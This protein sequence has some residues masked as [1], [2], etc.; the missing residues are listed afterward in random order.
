MDLCTVLR[1]LVCTILDAASC[2]DLRGHVAAWREAVHL[3]PNAR[4][5][6]RLVEA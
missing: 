2:G 6:L 1:E 3:D 4:L 5:D